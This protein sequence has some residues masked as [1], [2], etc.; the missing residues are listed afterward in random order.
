MLH[1]SRE[2]IVERLKDPASASACVN[3]TK[4]F[5]RTPGAQPR[6]FNKNGGGGGEGTP[7]YLSLDVHLSIFVV[8][9]GWC[10]AR[11]DVKCMS[12]GRE[13]T[14]CSA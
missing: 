10:V 12:R 7:G 3:F 2:Q 11:H 8:T 9:H 13:V 5:K 4:T 6:R 1:E 14:F